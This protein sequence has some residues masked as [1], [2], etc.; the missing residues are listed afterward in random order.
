ML[1]LEKNIM[2]VSSWVPFSS[3]K[4]PKIDLRAQIV[5]FSLHLSPN[6]MYFWICAH[7]SRAICVLGSKLLHHSLGLNGAPAHSWDTDLQ[8]SLNW[9]FYQIKVESAHA[10]H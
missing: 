2:V 10:L 6:F 4:F 5:D 3:S 7:R 1:K 8:N 9:I